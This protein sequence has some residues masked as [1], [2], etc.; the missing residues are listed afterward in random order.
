MI[1]GGRSDIPCAKLGDEF[2]ETVGRVHCLCY[3]K[4]IEERVT[5]RRKRR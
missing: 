2:R 4:L 3:V 5:C 1:T